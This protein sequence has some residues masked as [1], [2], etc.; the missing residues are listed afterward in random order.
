[1]TIAGGFGSALAGCL[2]AVGTTDTD[3]SGTPTPM[4]ER[5]GIGDRPMECP[6][7]EPGHLTSITPIP[8]PERP[9]RVTADTG[10]SY[11]R[12]YERFY[13]RYHAMADLGPQTPDGQSDV[14]AHEFP[15]VRMANLSA[16]ALDAGDGWVVVRLAYERVFEGESRGAYT[17]VYD[18]TPGR[19]VRTETDGRASP[20]PDPAE[21]GL[22]QQ[23]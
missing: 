16:D 7:D 8:L 12:S 13:L 15:D 21:H 4:V 5:A 20:G 2:S 17:V 1:M 14:S 22:V 18:V 3:A 6:R 9:D 10:V 23:C 19:T 11:A